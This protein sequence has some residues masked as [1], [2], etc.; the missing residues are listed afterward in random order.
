MDAGLWDVNARLASDRATGE[1]GGS[2]KRS[3]VIMGRAVNGWN[4]T[5]EKGNR[6]KAETRGRRRAGAHPSVVT[7][8]ASMKN[9]STYMLIVPRL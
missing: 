4:G 7:E 1:Q 6:D 5:L 3:L 8:G 9:R 2:M